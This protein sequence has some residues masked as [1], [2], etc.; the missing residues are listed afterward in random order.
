MAQVDHK[1]DITQTIDVNVKK[2]SSILNTLFIIFFL[3]FHFSHYLTSIT[4]EMLSINMAKG[5]RNVSFMK[6]WTIFH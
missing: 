6:I 1:D 4:T 3:F 5:V 2:F